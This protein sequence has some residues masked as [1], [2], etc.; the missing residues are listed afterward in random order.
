MV[1]IYNNNFTTPES[2]VPYFIEVYRCVSAADLNCGTGYYPMPSRRKEIEIVVPDLTNN[3]RGSSKLFYKYVVYNHTSC[4][5]GKPHLDKKKTL[6]KSEG[7]ILE[8]RMAGC[9]LVSNMCTKVPFPLI[10]R[11]NLQAR[12]EYFHPIT[13]L[14]SLFQWDASTHWELASWF[15]N[16]WKRT[17]W[18][19]NNFIPRDE[20]GVFC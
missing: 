15:C 17:L 13:M 2:K 16:Y 12:C 11:T 8:T 20:A 9:Y 14:E 4:E 19:T 7:K 5:C 10:A 6:Q 1:S 3:Y 18:L